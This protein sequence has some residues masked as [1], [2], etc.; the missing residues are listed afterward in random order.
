MPIYCDE[1][2]FTGNDALNIDQP[3][4]SYAAVNIEHDDAAEYLKQFR[5]RHRI[6]SPE[7]KGSALL[8]RPKGRDA[9]EELLI[10]MLPH[11][12]V[13]ISEKLF[14]LCGR[15][16]E[17]VFEPLFA[18]HNG[19]L[20]YSAFNQYIAVTVYMSFFP[21]KGNSFKNLIETF[22]SVMRHN[23]PPET[24]FVTAHGVSPRDV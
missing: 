9:A 15:F 18:G 4:F 23:T 14:S 6:K 24:L 1:S 2:G 11:S 3:Y 16:F 17:Y 5:E 21:Y 7:V 10:D 19:P 20:Y 22:E 8:S 12:R 13:Y